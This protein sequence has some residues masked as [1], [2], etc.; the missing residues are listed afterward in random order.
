MNSPFFNTEQRFI[1]LYDALAEGN[2]GRKELAEKIF[3]PGSEPSEDRFR[4]LVSEFMKLYKRF[5]AECEF[6]NNQAEQ[7]LM[8]L[9]RYM[10]TETREDFLKHANETIRFLGSSAVKDEIYYRNMVSALSMK[11]SVEDVNTKESS[12]DTSIVLNHYTD[13]YFASMKMFIFQRLTSLEY[14]FSANLDTHKTFYNELADFIEVNRDKLKQYDPEIYLRYIELKLDTEEFSEERYRDYLEILDAQSWQL[15]INSNYSS[16]LNL[17]SKFVNSGDHSFQ[18]KILE[19]SDQCQRLNLY[20]NHGISYI[21][22]K[23]II[24]NAISIGEYDKALVFAQENGGY[25]NHDQKESISFLML[26]K[27][28]FF[29]K[30]YNMS[31]TYLNKVSITDYIHYIEAK[32][33]SCRI[34]FELRNYVT[35]FEYVHTVK[36]FLKQ[37]TDIGR[38]FISAYNTFLSAFNRLTQ[39]AAGNLTSAEKNMELDLLKNSVLK[40]ESP[41]YAS[42]WLM[43]KIREKMKADH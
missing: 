28:Y 2:P 10:K 15:N 18:A 4:K 3:G 38:H 12:K 7:S 23:I 6:E 34:E 42:A 37:H 13:R 16:L 31:K 36:K 20:K 40:N 26:G 43:E 30:D 25:L 9:E 24:E 21:D 14:T 39:I 22:Y 32:L 11:Y 41:M 33:I 17:L 1:L 19:L 8:L 5:L 29:K 27:I 35:V